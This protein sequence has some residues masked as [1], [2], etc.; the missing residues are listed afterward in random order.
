M[1]VRYSLLH[2]VKT[3]QEPVTIQLDFFSCLCIKARQ[4]ILARN[5]ESLSHR[6][7]WVSEGEVILMLQGKSVFWLVSLKWTDEIWPVGWGDFD[8]RI[9]IPLWFCIFEAFIFNDIDLRNM[10]RV[11]WIDQVKQGGKSQ[12]FPKLKGQ[13]YREDSKNEGRICHHSFFYRHG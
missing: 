6:Q 9:D 3:W 5:S 13:I 11:F 1:E 12:F 2:G 4:V 10:A 7:Q 8:I